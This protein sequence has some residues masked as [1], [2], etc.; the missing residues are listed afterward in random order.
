VTFAISMTPAQKDQA[1]WALDPMGDFATDGEADERLYG[2][3]D[4]PTI[5]GAVLTFP[6]PSVAVDDILYRLTEQLRDMAD[7]AGE[8]YPR[9]ATVLA[10][11][12]RVAA[13]L[14]GWKE[15]GT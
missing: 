9:A 12:I 11:K 13:M 3:G 10:E 2:E 4:L 14:A 6:R 15:L 5:D 1:E 7:Q 8:R